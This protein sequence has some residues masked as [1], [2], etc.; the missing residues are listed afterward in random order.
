M[1]TDI[2]TQSVVSNTDQFASVTHQDGATRDFKLFIEKIGADKERDRYLFILGGALF[3]NGADVRAV[4]TI[5]QKK[6]FGLVQQCRTAWMKTVIDLSEVVDAN[7]GKR[8]QT[9]FQ[10]A[11]DHSDQSDEWLK[12]LGEN[13]AEAGQSLWYHVFR[14]EG[15]DEG[16]R[17]IG[18]LLAKAASTKALTCSITSDDFFLPWNLLYTPQS[19]DHFSWSGFWGYQHVIEHR[20]QNGHLDWLID[21]TGELIASFNFDPRI[22]QP[23]K[24]PCI[25]P[26]KSFF[27]KTKKLVLR[28]RTQ[29]AELK[30]DLKTAPFTDRITY[31]CCHGRTS[32][33]A[34]ALN[35]EFAQLAL[36]DDE[37]ITPTEI[38]EWLDGRH[39]ESNPFVFFNA[40]EA[41][42]MTTVFYESLAAVMLKKKARALLGSQIDIPVVFAPEYMRRFFETFLG[43]GD[44]SAR[45]LGP[46][47]RQLARDFLDHHKNPL[48]ITYSLYR[49][50]DCVVRRG[51]HDSDAPP[52]A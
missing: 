36:S 19:P 23:G 37:G 6:L 15:A 2:E 51:S 20:T 12:A 31:F 50:I 10:V 14:S 16:I 26:Q 5:D 24:T 13:L 47:V 44:E 7:P 41:G 9:P 29:K 42:Q 22:D 21:G 30:R 43:E 45:R 32:G 46:L 38:E 39:L 40:C 17:Q 49:G 8:N 3:P 27:A 35:L 52:S 1:R 34:G 28:E 48:A 11:W 18:T 33:T 4:L 25:E